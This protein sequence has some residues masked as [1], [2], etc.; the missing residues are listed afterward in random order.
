M[1]LN[2]HF[3]QCCFALLLLAAVRL[4]ALGA[5]VVPDGVVGLGTVAEAA[6]DDVGV[7]ADDVL[8]LDATDN[9]VVIPDL[10]ELCA[11]VVAGS[12]AGRGLVET[13][14]AAA[15]IGHLAVT[16]LEGSLDVGQAVARRVGGLDAGVGEP[17]PRGQIFVVADDS[18]EELE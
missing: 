13:G 18:L 12:L 16:R 3:R 6:A 8:A 1:R 10:L 15:E 9:V 7:N 17:V 2:I 14:A 4:A 5:L 11:A